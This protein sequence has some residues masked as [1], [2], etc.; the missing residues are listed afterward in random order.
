MQ[1]ST[2]HAAA[3]LVSLGA[4]L[5]SIQAWNANERTIAAHKGPLLFTQSQPAQRYVALCP[6]HQGRLFQGR[7]H[8]VAAGVLPPGMLPCRDA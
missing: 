5:S 7:K 6:A 4:R 8:A 3:L 1:F 2:S